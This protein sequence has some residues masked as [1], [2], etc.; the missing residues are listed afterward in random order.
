MSAPTCRHGCAVTGTLSPSVCAAVSVPTATSRARAGTSA[1][2]VFGA[3][4]A[5]RSVEDMDEGIRSHLRRTHAR[6]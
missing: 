4:P 3:P 5:R 1:T 6:G 2:A